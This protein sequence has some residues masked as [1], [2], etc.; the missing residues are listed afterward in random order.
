MI[1]REELRH[2]AD[3]ARINIPEE[4]EG[5]LVHDLAGILKHFE[6]LKSVKTDAVLPVTGGTELVGVVREDVPSALPG[7]TGVELF[8]ESDEGFLKVPA[9][10]SD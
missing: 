6:E 9:V 5:Q 8:P 7:K 3:L 2:L 1:S 10:F 4:R